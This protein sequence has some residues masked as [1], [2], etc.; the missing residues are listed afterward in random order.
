M[1]KGDERFDG[2]HCGPSAVVAH[3]SF[4]GGIF[5][6]SLRAFDVDD[7]VF[8]VGVILIIVLK[9]TVSYDHFISKQN[10]LII[11]TIHDIGWTKEYTILIQLVVGMRDR[12]ISKS[13]DGQELAPTTIIA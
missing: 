7:A 2:A 3:I 13:V 4:E 12:K 1:E 10:D 11:F 8:D 5:Y 6:K 9:R